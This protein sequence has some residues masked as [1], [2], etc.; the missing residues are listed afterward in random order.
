MTQVQINLVK[1]EI[2]QLNVVSG[3]ALIWEW[4]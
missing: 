1:I 3:R 4:S 2:F